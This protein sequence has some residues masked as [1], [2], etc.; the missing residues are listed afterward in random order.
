MRGLRF[1]DPRPCLDAEGVARDIPDMSRRGRLPVVVGG[2]GF[3]LRAL[4]TGL[5]DLPMRDEELRS[6]NCLQFRN[7]FAKCRQ[8]VLYTSGSEILV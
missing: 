1:H 6:L 7:L 4:L 2:T 5:P 3:Y 8:L